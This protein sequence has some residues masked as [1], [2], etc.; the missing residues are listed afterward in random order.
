MRSLRQTWEIARRDLTQ[1]ARSK[2]FLVSTGAIVLLVL[3]IGPLL[4]NTVNDPPRQE[5]GI[6][7]TLENEFEAAAR[8]A[9]TAFNLNLCASPSS[10]PS[11]PPKRHL[12]T[13]RCGWL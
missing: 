9:A 5:I 3:A 8:A 12:R 1:R 6:V 4:A 7:G 10:L 11:K 2:A 13:T